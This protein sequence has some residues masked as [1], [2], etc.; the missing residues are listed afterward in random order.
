MMTLFDFSKKKD[1]KTC[2]IPYPSPKYR[3]VKLQPSWS[4]F[5]YQS[6]LPPRS[7]VVSGC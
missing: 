1:N 5:P 7:T 2:N 3:L 4:Y 6:P